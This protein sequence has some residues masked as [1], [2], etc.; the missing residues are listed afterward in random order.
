VNCSSEELWFYWANAE[1]TEVKQLF[2]FPI[3]AKGGGV[4]DFIWSPDDKYAAIS[5]TSSGIDYMYVIDIEA[6]L[7]DPSRQP[8]QIALYG[9]VLSSNLSWQPLP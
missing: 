8:V 6:T 1:G 9:D 4:S 5:V 7:K 3:P 2:D